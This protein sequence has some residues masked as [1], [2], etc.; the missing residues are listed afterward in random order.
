M[1]K[2]LAILSVFILLAACSG[3]KDLVSPQL[4]MPQSFSQ[5]QS[6]DSMSV[7]DLD[8]WEF[9]TDPSLKE[10][11]TVAL[12]NNRDLLKAASK[13]EE[14]R[15]LY[16]VKKAEMLPQV[17]LDVGYNL[18]TNKYDGGPV[19]KD[20]EHDLKLPVTWEINLW[21]AM[22][23]AREAAKS[24]YIATAEDYRA[25]RMELIAEV[26]TAYVNLLSLENELEIVRH[27]LRTREE[28]LHQAKIRYEGGLTSE[29]VYQQAKVEF[30]STAAMVPDL[31]TRITATRNALTL[32]MGKFPEEQL[33]KSTFRFDRSL[34]SRLPTGF[35]SQLLKRRPDLRASEL[36]LKAAME[37]VGMTYAD[38]F[39]S[40]RI[41]FTPG[42]ENDGLKDFFKSPFSYTI[43]A[44]A[45][46]VFD[47]GRK[48][49]KY[50]AA[51][52]VYDQ[53]R[54]E[55]EKNVIQA[56]TEVNTAITD[57]RGCLENKQ[58][59]NELCEAAA[60]YVK[61]ATLQYRGGT[62]NYIDVLDAQRKY[63]SARTGVNSALRDQYLA[64]IN[65][66]KVLGGGCGKCQ[67]ASL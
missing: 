47:F 23:H 60:K 16:G 20:P 33:A 61:L 15:L 27:T 51:K 34:E 40:L 32:L 12:E 66:Y 41:G 50:E 9:F 22:A 62:L 17:G 38:R 44:I 59:M 6:P 42:F 28:S 8:W 49:K 43:G 3:T 4:E 64:L 30:A 10:I 48:K 21:G 2:F 31:E 29:T 46:T 55:Y 1:K 14:M 63:F 52:A 65:L 7:A 67:T 5:L 25:M 26:A 56:F 37:D 39:P 24:R 19:T 57:Y 18:E 13:I 45:G 36:R 35:P 11:M 58:L 54:Y 53:A